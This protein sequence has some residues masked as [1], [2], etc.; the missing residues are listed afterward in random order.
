MK[1][2]LR[3]ITGQVLLACTILLA[4]NPS[5]ALFEEAGKVN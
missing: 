3:R 2:N 5:V 1:P 4:L